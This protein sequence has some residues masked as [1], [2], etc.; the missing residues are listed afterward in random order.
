MSWRYFMGIVETRNL[1]KTYQNGSI[2]VRALK[3]ISMKIEE[4]EFVS[5]IGASG[6]GKSTLLKILGGLEVPSEGEVRIRNL[7]LNSMSEDELAVFRRRN[8]GFVFQNYNLLDTLNVRENILFPIKI[9]CNEVDVNFFNSIVDELG[10]T[11]KLL[12]MPEYLSGGQQQRV[13]IARALITK[14]AIILADEPTGN[15]DSETGLEVMKLFQKMAHKFNQT[16]IMVT[17]DM[18]IAEMADRI[19]CIKDGELSK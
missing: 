14:P 7:T 8:I 13:A 10:I 19:I 16:M 1:K 2:E 9:D 6:S 18:K 17:H 5:I 4:G 15:L 12:Q 11:D 3:R